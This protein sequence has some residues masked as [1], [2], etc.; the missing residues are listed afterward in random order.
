MEQ[1]SNYYTV[2]MYNKWSMSR[3]T[4]RTLGVYK[5]REDAQKKIDDITAG[6]NMKDS[7]YNFYIVENK[8]DIRFIK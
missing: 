2:K 4:E 3:K 1:M 6:K 7:N 5:S 8:G